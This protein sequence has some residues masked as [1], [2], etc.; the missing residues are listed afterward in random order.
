VPALQPGEKK[1]S[2]GSGDDN[3]FDDF[4]LYM[5]LGARIDRP[6][7][8][9]AADTFTSGSAL[10]YSSADKTCIRVAMEGANEP[11]LRTVMRQW[12]ATMPA[13]ALESSASAS[14]VV[15]HSCDPGKSFAAPSNAG[16]RQAMSFA[17]TRSAFAKQ[18][19]TVDHATAPLAACASRLFFESPRLRDVIFNKSTETEEQQR[20]EGAAVGLACRENP[21]S[22]LP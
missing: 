20:S 17:A 10:L 19:I 8:L 15:F 22:G 2:T 4:F 16:I 13:A 18:L 12:V 3:D 5:M 1:I 9:R 21:E 11:F 6:T 7:A 14:G